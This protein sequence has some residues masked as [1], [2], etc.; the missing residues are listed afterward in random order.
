ML[1]NGMIFYV[2]NPKLQQQKTAPGT[3]NNKWL[4]QVAG[5]KV[6]IRQFIFY[7]P[8]INKWNFNKIKIPFTPSTPKIKCL[9]INLTNLCPDLRLLKQMNPWGMQ[10][11]QILWRP[12]HL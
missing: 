9:G 8:A 11:A 3:I 5:Y 4:Q 10:R 7:I 1:E 12:H 6:N 2:E